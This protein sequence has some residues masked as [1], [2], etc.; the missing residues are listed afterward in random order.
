MGS[1]AGREVASP[2]ALGANSLLL[3]ARRGTGRGN[4]RLH[5]FSCPSCHPGFKNPTW[6]VGCVCHRPWHTHATRERWA[7]CRPRRFPSRQPAPCLEEGIASHCGANWF[8]ALVNPPLVA[9][10]S[11]AAGPSAT[12]LATKL[13]F[14]TL[15]LFLL[16]LLRSG[17]FR[18][19]GPP[20]YWGFID[21]RRPGDDGR[22][23]SLAR[24][25]TD[26]ARTRRKT[27]SLHQANPFC[28]AHSINRS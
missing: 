23:T 3:G 10:Q 2:G 4:R 9:P 19:Q 27:A 8:F 20:Y 28:S 13:M 7:F 26:P 25:L 1:P 24:R 15:F 5:P 12:G 21:R 16:L 6:V 18:P 11:H 22:L 17:A 14:L